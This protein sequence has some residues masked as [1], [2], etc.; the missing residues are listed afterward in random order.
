MKT[1]LGQK[2][3]EYI[4]S[5]SEDEFD[6]IWSEIEA[7]DLE[8]VTMKE[9]CEQLLLADVSRSVLVDKNYTMDEWIEAN[10]IKIVKN[11]F[12]FAGSIHHI[13]NLENKYKQM[14]KVAKHYY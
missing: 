14:L 6:K 2:F 9:Y 12:H 13:K 7:M 5:L 11:Y 4:D 8:G 1:K 10:N 3:K